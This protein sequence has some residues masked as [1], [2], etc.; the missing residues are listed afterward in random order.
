[1][2]Q[3]TTGK[4]LVL[5]T[6]HLKGTYFWQLSCHYNERDRTMRHCDAVMAQFLLCCLEASTIFDIF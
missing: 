4:G 3:N 2:H 6:L 1:M 5:L